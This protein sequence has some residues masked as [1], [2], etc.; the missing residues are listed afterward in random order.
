MKI[1]ISKDALKKI[2]IPLLICGLTLAVLLTSSVLLV[3]SAVV[4]D[5]EKYIK[6]EE[7]ADKLYNIDCIIVLGALVRNNGTPSDMLRDRL[8]VAIALYKMG[9]SDRI[10]MSGDH[11]RTGYNEVGIMKKYAL[12]Q[13]VQEEHIFMD[14]AGFSTYETMVRA[15]EVFLTESHYKRVIVVTQKY[16][17]HRALYIANSI[18]LDAYGVA[19]D[20]H[21]YGGQTARDVR[22]VLARFK[23]FFFC[24]YGAEPKYLGGPIS[25]F[26]NG[27]DT[28]DE[29]YY[30]LFK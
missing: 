28:N 22:E 14:H 6:T 20:L 8:D 26:G 17:L 23:D 25:I 1:K 9:V 13:G 18:G 11:G 12:E 4:G 7:E 24:Y 15:K 2:I 30:D 5:T 3:S 10:L 19:S 16:H 27:N 21:T 29:Y